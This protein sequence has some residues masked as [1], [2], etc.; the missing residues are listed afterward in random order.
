MITT[1]HALDDLDER[2]RI[3]LSDPDFSYVC[4]VQPP[5]VQGADSLGAMP[6]LLQQMREGVRAT[7]LLR[8][9]GPNHEHSPCAF[10]AEE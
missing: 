10:R 3:R 9:H 2:L 8:T 7:G 4:Y 6:Q 1:N 5:I